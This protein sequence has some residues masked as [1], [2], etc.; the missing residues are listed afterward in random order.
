MTS[1]LEKYLGKRFKSPQFSSVEPS[2]LTDC[3]LHVAFLFSSK[4]LCWGKGKAKLVYMG[5]GG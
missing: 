5:G 1:M 2:Q 4:Q 3:F